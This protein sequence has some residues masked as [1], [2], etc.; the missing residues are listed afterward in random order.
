[1]WSYKYRVA[2]CRVQGSFECGVISI[3]LRG[4]GCGVVMSMEHVVES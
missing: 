4:A 1:M 3:E 2:G